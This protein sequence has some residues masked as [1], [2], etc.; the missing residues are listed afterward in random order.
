MP[1]DLPPSFRGQA[2]KY[3]Y[4]LKVGL[5]RLGAAVKMLHLPLRVMTWQGMY[6]TTQLNLA[7]FIRKIFFLCVCVSPALGL[8]ERKDEEEITAPNPFLKKHPKDSLLDQALEAM[9]V[10]SI[11]LHPSCILYFINPLFSFHLVA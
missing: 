7:C 9:Q 1:C 10:K 5:Q 6:D 11:I 3:S 2:V 8:S 4:K